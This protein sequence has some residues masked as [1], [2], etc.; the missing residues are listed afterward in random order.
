ME[1]HT[2]GSFSASEALLQEL[3][4]SVKTPPNEMIFREDCFPK[5]LRKLKEKTE[6]RILQ[7]LSHLL[8]PSAKA[9]AT[10][11]ADHLNG[12]VESVNEGWNNCC[13]IT[14]PRPQ[15]DSAFSFGASFLSAQQLDKPRPA[16][17]DAT[18]SL[19]FKATCYMHFAVMA[20]EVKTGT[21]GL[22]IADN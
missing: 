9:L 4:H 20:N 17:G 10:L 18:F 19:D 8:V 1:D 22:D 2:S 7:D 11:G 21:M 15:P 6:S 12:I 3:L 16:L 5:H 14:K 13:P